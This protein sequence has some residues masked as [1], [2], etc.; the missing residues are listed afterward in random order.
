[1]A[2]TLAALLAQ[3]RPEGTERVVLVH[4]DADGPLAEG[5][6]PVTAFHSAATVTEVD[7]AA[8]AEAVLMSLLP[9]FEV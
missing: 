3:V 5:A 2:G 8:T 1:M 9:A 7:D 6:H 4:A